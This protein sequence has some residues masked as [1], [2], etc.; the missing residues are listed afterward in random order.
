MIVPPIS[1]KA[2]Y[3]VHLKDELAEAAVA[4]LFSM[5]EHINGVM[6]LSTDRGSDVEATNELQS[7]VAKLIGETD[8]NLEAVIKFNPMYLPHA[9]DIDDLELDA[10]G[11]V[12][13]VAGFPNPYITASVIAERDDEKLIDG[14]V[15]FQT[16]DL[17]SLEQALKGKEHRL[18]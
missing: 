16:F 14:K 2:Y 5:S 13:G 15:C 4:N 3:V 7:V 17:P 1:T 6:V 12:I 9:E 11:E 8:L 10:E 18:N